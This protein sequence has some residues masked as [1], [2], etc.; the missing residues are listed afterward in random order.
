MKRM[1]LGAG[2]IQPAG[3]VNVDVI[4]RRRAVTWDVLERP[5][6]ELESFDVIVCN[7]MLSDLSFH[8]LPVALKNI[9]DILTHGGILRVMVP[10]IILLFEAWKRGDEAVFP[11]DD[12]T[13]SID[14][15]FCTMVTWF[16][17]VKSVFTW[18]YLSEIL[19][20]AGFE[21]VSIPLNCG[22]TRFAHPSLGIT[23]LD[24]RCAEALIVEA[25]K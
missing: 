11:Q 20:A 7:H 21:D 10:D 23:D 13:G 12:T 2:S 3:W 16:G 25:V 14:A 1:N 17:T 22:Q 6:A 19:L 24:D 8:E 5:P 15:K 9:Y 18:G 4:G